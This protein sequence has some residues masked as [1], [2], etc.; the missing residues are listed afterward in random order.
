MFKS[1][2]YHFYDPSPEPFISSLYN[3][4]WSWLTTLDL[5]S[6]QIWASS[7][8]PRY[9]L[10]LSFPYD[11]PLCYCTSW[12][13]Y[14]LSQVNK[15]LLLITE[16]RQ[17]IRQTWMSKLPLGSTQVY[18]VVGSKR[19]PSDVMSGLL[20]ERSVHND[21]MALEDLEVSKQ[22]YMYLNN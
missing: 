1:F 11:K 5:R 2:L 16:R 9:M 20:E 18:F 14:G 22:G 4:V 17:V 15:I 6:P 7:S 8:S 21:L 10:A 19:L 3:T 12:S 13:S